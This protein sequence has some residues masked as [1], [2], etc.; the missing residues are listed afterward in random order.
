[1][2]NFQQA[3]INVV[4]Q[5]YPEFRTPVIRAARESNGDLRLFQEELSSMAWDYPKLPVQ[6]IMDRISY[7]VA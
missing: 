1:M 2:K 3:V 7:T 4:N 5:V 6:D